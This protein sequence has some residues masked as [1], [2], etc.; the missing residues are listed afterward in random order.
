MLLFVACIFSLFLAK[1]AESPSRKLG[2]NIISSIP[3]IPTNASAITAV[4]QIVPAK[5]L[6]YDAKNFTLDG[7]PIR[8]ISGSFHYFRVP[9]SR[10]RTILVLARRMGLNAI[11]TYVPWN[12]HEPVERTFRFSGILD[13]ARFLTLAQELG[14]LVILRPGPYICSE[15]DLGGLPPYLLADRT[16]RLRSTHSRYMTAVKRYIKALSEVISPFIGRPIVALQIEN[17]YG[18][19]NS[20]EVYMR[21]L[22]ETWNAVGFTRDRVMH[23]TSDNGDADVISNGSPFDSA[24]LLKTINFGQ[25]VDNRMT[26]LRTLQPNAPLMVMEFWI[27]WY[28]Q[29]GV[30]HNTR[31][32][33]KISEM[34]R[35]IIFKYDGNVNLYMFIGGTNFGFMS[36]ANSYEH[37]LYRADTTSY[38]Y[39]A[40]LNEYSDVRKSKF[41]PVRTVL[42]EFWSMLGDTD[43]E[44]AMDDELPPPPFMS[45]Y[46]ESVP[47]TASVPMFSIVD[48]IA[49]K[50][51]QAPF[52]RPMEE[53]GGDYGYVVYRHELSEIPLEDSKLQLRGVHDYATILMDGVVTQTV[54]RNKQHELLENGTYVW[55]MINVPANT[56]RIDV[57]VENSGRV[58]YGASLHDRKGLIGNMTLDGA[59]LRNFDMLTLSFP[60]DHPLLHDVKNRSVI[61]TIVELMNGSYAHAT[62]GALS[63]PPAFFHGVLTLNSTMNEAFSGEFPSTHCRVFGRGVLWIN[64]FNVGRF[65]TGFS[66]PQRSLFIPGA[67]LREGKNDIVVL[68]TNLHLT[69]EPAHVT[70]FE[71]PDFGAV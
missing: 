27:G 29:W 22:V 28:D 38:D 12:W 44:R 6:S 45:A 3:S 41:N 16:M 55:K 48:Q 60:Q 4:G 37:D 49:D 67:L 33:E 19:F 35:D 24:E 39:D 8:L 23:F 32:G 13:L 56:K 2:K 71:Q 30:K 26:L 14:L 69:R 25:H 42:R 40:L 10:W 46:A 1:S 21:S 68:H 64:G 31:H 61:S 63:S 54:D 50:Q 51:A 36:G 62:M 43:M 52:P 5:H 11:E 58:N 34:L 66:M 20:D 18:Q 65:N 7:R 47:L 15:W 70:F 9:P 17:E 57:L 59:I 53:I